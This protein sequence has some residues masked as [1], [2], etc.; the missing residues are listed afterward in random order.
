MEN[1]IFYAEKNEKLKGNFGNHTRTTNLCVAIRRN[2]LL[3][4]AKPWMTLKN[5][6]I[7]GRSQS[8]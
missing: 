2:K 7:S 5:V 8:P 6:T 3:T 1:F 4:H